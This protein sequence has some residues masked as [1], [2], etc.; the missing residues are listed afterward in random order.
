M[1]ISKLRKLVVIAPTDGADVIIK[2]LMSLRCIDIADF[3]GEDGSDLLKKNDYSE[4]ISLLENKIQ[5][6]ECVIC[7]IYSR[8]KKKLHFG[9]DRIKVSYDAITSSEL[10]LAEEA[11]D[12]AY[13]LINE[14]EGADLSALAGQ[15]D[16][17]R[18]LYD[19]QRTKLE[20]M[21]IKAK[22][23]FSDNCTFIVGWMPRRAQKR[24]VSALD[25]Y[26]CAYEIE[27]PK[28][29]DEPPCRL[30]NN[31]FTRCFEWITKEVGVSKYRT[32]DPTFILSIFYFLCFGLMIPDVGYGLILS[33]FG[34]S[35][36]LIS[37]MRGKMRSV[38]GML[39]ICGVSSMIFGVLFGGWFGNIPYA[40]MQNL[41]GIENASEIAPFF[42]G[43][44]FK[45]VL[46]PIWYLV[47]CLA[48]GALQILV[49]MII[50]FI[51][52]CRGGR[53]VDALLD[54]LPFWLIF[55]AVAI[56]FF[57]S[58]LVGA[59]LA[60]VGVLAII[61]FGGRRKKGFFP[62]LVGGLAGVSRIALYL[63]ALAS[64]LKIF[65]VGFGVGVVTYYIN[66]LGTLLGGSTGGYILFV[67][68]SVV[69]HAICVG[70]ATFVA[71]VV[72][73]KLQQNEFFRQFHVSDGK[74]FAPA[75]ISNKYTV[76]ICNK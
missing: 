4:Q 24:V 15:L 27:E 26:V 47:V 13:A 22:A 58:W 29:N 37:G 35:A 20:E 48:I 74:A 23:A 57:T 67:A 8:K 9:D 34:V 21:N 76:D 61:I 49:G 63:V 59:I 51:L 70:G 64:Y 43:L 65:V 3:S 73:K 32:F 36:M 2:K 55:G 46:K 38:F 11:V 14:T 52:L 25:E 68:T 10:D 31:I 7:A 19:V 33:L 30:S 28:S 6:I 71:F 44:W 62:R 56:A 1:S 69:C 42:G 5:K 12:N 16:N 17:I 41:F 54:I 66:K 50:K 40:V 60:I 45:P 53:A 39:A 18:V 72:A 75:E